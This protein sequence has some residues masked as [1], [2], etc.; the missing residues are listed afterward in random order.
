MIFLS[1]NITC[2]SININKIN[3]IYEKNIHEEPNKTCISY[4]QVYIKIAMKLS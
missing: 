2:N 4:N 1:E 3:E